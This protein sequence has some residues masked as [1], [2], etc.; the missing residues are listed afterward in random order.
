MGLVVS[1]NACQITVAKDGSFF[2][3]QQD[4]RSVFTV[5]GVEVNAERPLNG[6]EVDRVELPFNPSHCD[7]LGESDGLI[8]HAAIA[9]AMRHGSFARA[10][11]AIGGGLTLFPHI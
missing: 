4:C 2:Q 5:E 8:V 7:H 3:L 1:G 6:L 9:W 10:S 11:A